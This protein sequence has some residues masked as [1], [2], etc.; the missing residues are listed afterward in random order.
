MLLNQIENFFVSGHACSHQVAEVAKNAAP[1]PQITQR[2][3]PDHERMGEHSSA[4]QQLANRLLPL[5]RWSTQTDMST[6]IIPADDD[7]AG[8]LRRSGSLP[9]R[10]ARRRALSRSMSAFEGLAKDVRIAPAIL[11][12]RALFLSKSVVQSH[13]R[14]TSSACMWRNCSPSC[15]SRSCEAGRWRRCRKLRR[16][17]LSSSARASRRRGGGRYEVRIDYPHDIS[18]FAAYSVRRAAPDQPGRPGRPPTAARFPAPGSRSPPGQ[19]APPSPP[20]S[21]AT[22]RGPGAPAMISRSTMSSWAIFLGAFLP[23]SLR[24][25]AGVGGQPAEA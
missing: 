7:G 4:F 5:R 25:S 6:R 14:S 8:R 12:K 17:L 15:T 22:N 16:T 9:P 2:K 3:L 18:A 13:E 21:Y 24:R 11:S 10:R 1:V 23:Q 20:G 19:S